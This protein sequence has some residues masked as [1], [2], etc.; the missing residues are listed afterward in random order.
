VQQQVRAAAS[1]RKRITIGE[2]SVA[3]AQKSRAG[4]QGMYDE[5]LS[6]YL[7]VLD[8]ENQLVQAERSLLREQVEYFLTTV[9]LR[10]ALGEDV[11]QGLPE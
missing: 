7:R 6:D 1:S 3:L 8:S 9:R 2:Q 11:T 10:R 4:A 5:G